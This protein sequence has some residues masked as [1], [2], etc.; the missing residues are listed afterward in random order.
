MKYAIL[1]IETTGLKPYT[2]TIVEVAAVVIG[3][4]FSELE[5][6]SS[7]VNPGQDVFAKADPK[8]LEVNKLTWDDI[9]DAPSPEN[10]AKGLQELLGRH[11]GV[12]LHSYPNE[13]DCRFLSL[14]PW[15]QGHSKWGE[16]IMAAA[17]EIMEEEDA[18]LQRSDG[19]YKRPKLSEAATF[20]GVTSKGT[21]RALA[22]S[23]VAADVFIEI[24]RRRPSRSKDADCSQEAKHFMNEG[25]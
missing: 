16:C 25:Y 22:D 23:R 20:F 7:L 6:W 24:L 9:K 17:M 14:A 11:P 2:F 4:D 19:S 12:T 5:R 21:H 10:A 1:D 3:Q 15:N 18:L 13:F 8:A